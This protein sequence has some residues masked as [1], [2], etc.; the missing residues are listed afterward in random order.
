M[1]GTEA[2][3]ATASGMAAILLMC[4]GLLQARATT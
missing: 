2:A 1:E 4:M 3:M